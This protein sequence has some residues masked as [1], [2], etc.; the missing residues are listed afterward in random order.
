[1]GEGLQ[2][3]RL[4]KL[5]L[6][7]LIAASMACLVFAVTGLLAGFIG[8]SSI[9]SLRDRVGQSL[10][11]DARRMAE[12]LD[13]EMF[14]RTRDLE[15]LEA[16]RPLNGDVGSPAQLANMR[17]M[18]DALMQSFPSYRWLAITDREGRVLV[19]TSPASVGTVFSPRAAARDRTRVGPQWDSITPNDDEGREKPPQDIGTIEVV[20]PLRGVDGSVQ[21]M[22]VA[23]LSWDWLRAI[24][25]TIIAPDS[26]GVLRREIFVVSYQD[27]VL[28]GPDGAAGQ[29]LLL[30]SIERAR[31]GFSGWMV[32]AWPDGH[33]YLTGADFSAGE[34]PHPGPGSQE[35]RWTTLVREPV[36]IALAPAYKLR[37]LIMLIGLAIG[38]AFAAI[39]WF[40][41]G[42]ITRP[43]QRIAA[44]AERL[45]QGDDIE[46][47][48]ITGA[49]EIA[50]LSDSLRALVASLM[51]TEVALN[52]LQGRAS[53]DPLTGLLNRSG[54]NEQ[55]MKAMS[56]AR[57]ERASILVFVSDLDGFKAVNDTYGHAAG[58]KL[59]QHV[60]SRLLKSL[61]PRDVV[62]RLGGD[63]FVIALHAP[64]GCNDAAAFNVTE[65]VRAA[66]TEPYE[67]GGNIL[68]VGC[69][70]GGACWPEHAP[71]SD[72]DLSAIHAVMETAD[73]AMYDAKRTRKGS[74]R[75]HREIDRVSPEL[76]ELVA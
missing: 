28:V 6:R 20:H 2:A 10:S 30:K 57:S 34:G 26:D 17:L 56:C 69:S 54:F 31:A 74:V 29:T 65:R 73:A 53:R 70:L 22:A 12:R 4:R 49:A 44:A 9:S 43:L 14:A 40:V 42:R 52:D 13:A 62:G 8:E 1:M 21:G 76:L 50:S 75:F 39:G 27:T 68:R 63:E 72:V 16:L 37:L 11:V 33:R 24:E 5:S 32:E 64:S 35:M 51:H 71:S 58:D 46:L 48:R 19:S 15:L 55:L 18:L 3:G 7:T 67:V 60:A 25:R 36:E 59:L 61:R 23:E 41:A 66:I 38:V 47:P 45:R